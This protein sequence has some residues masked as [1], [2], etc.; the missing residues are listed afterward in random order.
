MGKSM[1]AVG[2]ALVFFG[3][4]AFLHDLTTSKFLAS[5]SIG[6]VIDS[7]DYFYDYRVSRYNSLLLFFP[8]SYASMSVGLVIA[9][10]GAFYHDKRQ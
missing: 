5:T 9:I 1:F 2:F 3:L 6:E 7:F 4:A 8:F 10:A